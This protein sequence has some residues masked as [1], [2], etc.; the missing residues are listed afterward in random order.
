MAAPPGP[1]PWQH[2]ALRVTATMGAN[3]RARQR[4]SRM[5]LQ[6]RAALVTGA[7][8][9]LGVEIARHYVAAGASVMVCARSAE[10]LEAVAVDLRAQ[11][12]AGQSVAW[13]ACDVTDAAA[14]ERLVAA[15]LEAFGSLHVL[16]NNA[17]VI[18]P[19]GPL[20][21]VDWAEWVRTIEI[22]LYGTVYPCRAVLPHFQARGYG[23]IVNLSGG[24]ATNPGHGVGG[25]SSAQSCRPR[26]SWRKHPESV[27][28]GPCFQSALRAYR[29]AHAPR[30]GPPWPCLSPT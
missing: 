9:G 28:F 1:A 15:T 24:G 7:S 16:V 18:G 14:V 2:P 5:M 30:R 26:R 6:G 17:G 27:F 21:D 29:C 4:E 8:E 20:E 23:K 3:W 10:R 11:L 19:L 22:N 13:M 25:P 12:A